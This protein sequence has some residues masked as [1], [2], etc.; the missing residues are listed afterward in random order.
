[1]D[2]DRLGQFTKD[3]LLVDYTRYKCGAQAADVIRNI[4]RLQE[5]TR[6][7]LSYHYNV[8]LSEITRLCTEY[9]NEAEIGLEGKL[10]LLIR[11]G[12]EIRQIE[13]KAAFFL[14]P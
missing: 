10:D 7:V 8:T 13:N 12:V 1:M 4:L 3:Q 5:H 9:G 6:G 2:I 14:M 11:H